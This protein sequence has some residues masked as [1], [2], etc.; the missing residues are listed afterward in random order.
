MRLIPQERI[1]QRTVEQ[2]IVV[3]VL[4]VV[5]EMIEVDPLFLSFSLSLIFSFSL[6]FSA[7][8]RLLSGFA[9]AF[10]FLLLLLLCFSCSFFF[11]FLFFF[12]F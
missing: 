10:C 6:D 11:F 5:K 8:F 2:I 3:P 1:Q 4:E 9:F 12:F 7:L